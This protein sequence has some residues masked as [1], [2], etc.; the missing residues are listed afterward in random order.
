MHKFTETLTTIANQI[1]DHGNAALSKGIQWFGL[2]SIGTGG[3]LS[4]AKQTGVIASEKGLELADYG[5]IVSIIGGVTFI[6]KNIADIYF[7]HRKNKRED[8]A[9][10][11]D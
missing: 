1:S 7:T 6:I 5:I 8:K 10:E 9:A 4:A 11:K 2:T 3:G